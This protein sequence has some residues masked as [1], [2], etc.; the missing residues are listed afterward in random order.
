MAGQAQHARTRAG[1]KKAS[2]QEPLT[3]FGVLESALASARG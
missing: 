2:P 3:Q 1:V